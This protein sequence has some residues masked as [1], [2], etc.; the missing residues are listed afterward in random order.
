[1]K[2]F[3]INNNLIISK[4]SFGTSR[5]HHSFLRKKRISLLECAL[6]NGITHYDTSPYYGYGIAEKD[7]G[8][9]I[10]KH[11]N[12]KITV[13][14]KIGIGLKSNI[15][16]NSFLLICVKIIEKV[17]FKNFLIKRDFTLPYLKKSFNKSLKN[18]NKIDILFIHE[19]FEDLID[20]NEV[21]EWINELMSKKKII[22]W[23]VSGELKSINWWINKSNSLPPIIQ[24]KCEKG[25]KIDLSYFANKQ[26]FSY[27]YA[28]YTDNKSSSLLISNISKSLSNLND[29]SVLI[30]S[31]NKNHIMEVLSALNNKE[32]I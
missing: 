8:F 16:F 2:S 29:H 1:M 14:T 31:S 26:Y 18:L 22:N 25:R 4:I 12:K 30:S 23:G 7:I 17:F 28:S 5:L 27:G 10:K 11:K 3:N 19:P 13:A 6:N 15:E 21:M 24:L 9:L 32:L 20:I